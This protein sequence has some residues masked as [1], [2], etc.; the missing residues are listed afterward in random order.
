ME[1]E[2]LAYYTPLRGQ[3]FVVED[4]DLS[5]T[6]TTAKNDDRR[7]TSA[8]ISFGHEH[9]KEIMCN[10]SSNV[11][12]AEKENPMGMALRHLGRGFGATSDF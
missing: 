9:L 3:S 5:R 7:E 12:L 11:V 4:C 6:G 2:Q 1:N 8:S 10:K